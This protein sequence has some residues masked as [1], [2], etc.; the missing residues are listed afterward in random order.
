MKGKDRLAGQVALVAGG[1]T[2]LGRDIALALAAR[3]VRVVVAGEG[4]RALAETV[5][6]IACG[7]GKAR[8]LVGDMRDQGQLC[9]AMQSAITI[10][11][12]LDV[13]VAG[14]VGTFEAAAHG[15]KGPGQLL[16]ILGNDGG[17]EPEWDGEESLGDLVR[18]LAPELQARQILSHGVGPEPGHKLVEL[19]LLL[20]ARPDVPTGLDLQPRRLHSRFKSF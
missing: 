6:E 16:A 13:V 18:T 5:G 1:G 3:G 20:L 15:M 7:G 12:G 10:F 17:P 14:S 8:H 19:V 9:A 4:E 11:G 2:G